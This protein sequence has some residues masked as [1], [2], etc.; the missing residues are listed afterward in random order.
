MLAG[1]L[2]REF[3]L[4]IVIFGMKKATK[5]WKC[6]NS[7]DLQ[8]VYRLVFLGR[9][10]ITISGVRSR[11]TLLTI[12]DGNEIALQRG[13]PFWEQTMILTLTAWSP[14]ERLWIV[15]SHIRTASY[16]SQTNVKHEVC[17]SRLQITRRATRAY[18]RAF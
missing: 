13:M 15:P 16:L 5:Q 14:V 10:N 12:V 6:M 9:P 7:N 8:L 17:I 2:E 18:A 3:M 1:L 4:E 11:N